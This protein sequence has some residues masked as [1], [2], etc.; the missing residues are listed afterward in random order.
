MTEDRGLTL[1]LLASVLIVL[2]V[3]VGMVLAR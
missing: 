1:A 3:V 2:G